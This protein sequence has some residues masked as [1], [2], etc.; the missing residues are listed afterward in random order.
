V[1]TTGRCPSG[2]RLRRG[3][4]TILGFSGKPYRQSREVHGAPLGD[5]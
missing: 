5:E 2:E 4:A 1:P 3:G